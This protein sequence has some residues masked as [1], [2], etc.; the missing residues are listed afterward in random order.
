MIC[1]LCGNLIPDEA[2]FITTVSINTSTGDRRET[3]THDE[4]DFLRRKAD[5]ADTG[6]IRSKLWLDAALIHQ[7]REF[8]N[9]KLRSAHRD[10]PWVDKVI[11]EMAPI[12]EIAKEWEQVVWFGGQTPWEDDTVTEPYPGL[13]EHMGCRSYKDEQGPPP[14]SLQEFVVNATYKGYGA[15]VEG[16]QYLSYSMCGRS[17]FQIAPEGQED[18]YISIILD[19]TSAV[20]RGGVNKLQATPSMALELVQTAIQHWE[21]GKI[22][23]EHGEDIGFLL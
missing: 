8:K 2:P 23:L 9:V 16:I 12:E 20:P 3:F 17:I 11:G 7:G 22:K 21:D 13:P 18:T 6:V 4:C 1:T 10:G 15:K 5:Y 19:E 14:G